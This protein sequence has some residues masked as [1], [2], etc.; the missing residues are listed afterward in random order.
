MSNI[1]APSIRL[2]RKL[3]EAVHVSARVKT[4]TAQC[5]YINLTCVIESPKRII[6]GHKTL[7]TV[8]MITETQ[9]S[10]RLKV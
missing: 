9:H 3:K 5:D 10:L 2:K 7:F 4:Q 1:R 6:W 8:D